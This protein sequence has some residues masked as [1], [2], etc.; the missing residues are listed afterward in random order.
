MPLPFYAPA[1]TP[2][3]LAAP[4]VEMDLTIAVELAGVLVGEPEANV[5]IG[6]S[7]GDLDIVEYAIDG[8]RVDA[9]RWNAASKAER[10][11]HPDIAVFVASCE[12]AFDGAARLDAA[13]RMAEAAS[14]RAAA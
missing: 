5:V 9:Y 2:S 6:W 14:E 4:H 7:N 12:R 13:D 3:Y 1:P 11:E 8:V 10:A